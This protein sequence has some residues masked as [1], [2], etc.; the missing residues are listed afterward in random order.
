MAKRTSRSGLTALSLTDLRSELRRRS[1]AAESLRR[2][3]TKLVRKLEALDAQIHDLGGS[4][5]PN[6]H[7][8]VGAIPGRKRPRNESNLAEALAK[9]LKGKTMGVTEV[10]EAVQKAGSQTTAANFRTIVNQCLIKNNK[11]FKKIGRGQYTAA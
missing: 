4:I 2:R 1:R 5:G 9:V 7:G 11:V 10:A 6:G 8:R 3:R